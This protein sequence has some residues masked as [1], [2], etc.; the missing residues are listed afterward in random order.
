MAVKYQDM[1][2]KTGAKIIPFCGHDSIPW[3]LLV[4]RMQQAMENDKLKSV[5][6]WDETVGGFAGG[7]LATLV[8]GMEGKLPSAPESDLFNGAV[9]KDLP[10]VPRQ[11]SS[12][13]DG[14][15]SPRWTVPFFMA[16]VNSDVVAWSHALRS[17]SPLTYSEKWLLPD[18]ASAMT[19]Y[20]F[21]VIGVVSMLN[22]WTLAL[23]KR[24]VLTPPGEGPDMK[25][26]EEKHFLQVSGEGIGQ[27]GTRVEAIL[28]FPGDPGCME[29]VRMMMEAA[30]CLTQETSSLPQRDGGFWTPSTALGDPLLRRIVET[31]S[32]LDVRVVKDD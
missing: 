1:A 30:L 8:S 16:D 13:W 23:L 20:A 2:R 27:G 18:I 15:Q 29:T 14:R 25:A 24:Y 9:T 32:T 26:M 7:T 19:M 21:M 28:Y 17:G 12:P 6:F 22:P 10:Y 11:A 3:D 4:L 5:R 31:G